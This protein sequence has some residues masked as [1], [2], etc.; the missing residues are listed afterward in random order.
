MFICPLEV[1]R[2]SNAHNDHKGETNMDE[3]KTVTTSYRRLE[4]VLYA[5]GYTALRSFKDW[6]GST[7]WEYEDTPELRLIAETL[8]ELDA[9][10]K[11]IK[12]GAPHD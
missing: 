11:A 7:I 12:E 4:N 6:D 10:L 1:V 8:K 3:K 2:R 9:K 5:L